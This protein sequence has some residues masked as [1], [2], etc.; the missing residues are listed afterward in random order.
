MKIVWD[1]VADRLYSA[2]VSNGILFQDDGTGVAWNG[3][4]SVTEAGDGEQTSFLFEGRRYYSRQQGGVFAGTIAAYT[5]PD[6]FEPYIGLIGIGTA[7]LRRPFG[8]SYQTNNEIHIVYNALAAP[9]QRQYQTISEQAELTELEWDFTTLPQEI[10]GGKPTSHIVILLNNA[11]A[12]AISELQTI[13]Y[14]VDA[15]TELDGDGNPITPSV[16][17]MLPA[18]ADIVE[19]FESHTTMRVTDNGDGTWTATGP[20]SVISLTG[21]NTFQITA[22]TAFLT[23]GNTFRISSF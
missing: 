3:L 19:I 15:S 14:G 8:F 13:M 6:E 12:D 20:D 11:P 18:I 1:A 23:E 7:Q 17:P 9:S 10:P 22:P 4:I 5:Y 2:G 16:D 21:P